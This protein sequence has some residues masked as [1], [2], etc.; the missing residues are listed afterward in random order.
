GVKWAKPPRHRRGNRFHGAAASRYF[1][2]P[3][4][5]S[6][7]MFPSRSGLS[8]RAV[9]PPALSVAARGGPAIAVAGLER[10]QP[11]ER[12]ADIG[13]LDLLPWCPAGDPGVENAVGGREQH[14]GG[15][16][17]DAW[18]QRVPLGDQP[19]VELLRRSLPA[20]PELLDVAFD[21]PCLRH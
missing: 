15:E 3:R 16:L 11:G 5:V 1:G 7:T 18:A 17:R 14:G 9:C 19:A 8:T 10:S 12:E 6:S 21:Q 4:C 13:L 2:V 20:S